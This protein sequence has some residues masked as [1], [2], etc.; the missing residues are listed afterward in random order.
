MKKTFP[1][2]NLS[3]SSDDP[4]QNHCYVS[5]HRQTCASTS[6]IPSENLQCTHHCVNQNSTKRKENYARMTEFEKSLFVIGDYPFLFKNHLGKFT[7][8]NRMLC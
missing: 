1:I 4:S 5:D 7:E 6:H 8:S 2:L 3:H